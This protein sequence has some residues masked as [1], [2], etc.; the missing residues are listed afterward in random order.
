MSAA[1][2]VDC[3]RTPVGRAHPESGYFRDERA[4]E[5]AAACVSALIEHTKLEPAEIE[6]VV[7]GCTQ[8]SGEQGLNVARNVALL[9]GLPTSVAGVT[10]NRLCG[11]SLQAI[12]QSAH[13]IMAGEQHVQIVG[14][15]EHMHHLPMGSNVS[16][17]PKLFSR[18][19]RAAWQMGMTAEFLAERFQIRRAAQ[20]EFALR[21]HQRAAKAQLD[22]AFRREIVPVLGRDETGSRALIQHDQC[23]RADANLAALSSLPPAFLKPKGTVTAGNSSPL[24]D[25]AAAMLMMSESRARSLGLTPLVR[26][27]ASAVVGVEPAL[28]GLG[29]VLAI[30]KLLQSTRVE[31]RDIGLFEI[32]EAFAVQALA[33][34]QE[35]GLDLERTNI[36]GGALAIGHPLGA[37]GA[38][39]ATTLIQTMQDTNVALGVAAMC[40][41]FGQGIAVMFER[42]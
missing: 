2:I 13:A 29:P 16:V 10:V 41:G 40:I 17:N 28:M 21:S 31:L 33:C 18:T 8:Q 14:G 36:R 20:D 12:R 5:L 42:V 19:S 3:V 7:L 32:N 24:N 39:I 37:S 23:I 27:R 11:S 4:D 9:A 34:I 22:G 38:R 15:L 30:R 1:V 6:D 25:G 35:L 26:V